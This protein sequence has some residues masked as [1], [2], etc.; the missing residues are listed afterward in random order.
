MYDLITPQVRGTLEIL[1]QMSTFA[2]V[3]TMRN[4]KLSYDIDT[5]FSP[6]SP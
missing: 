5:V 2:T 1:S 3:F 6:Y 4:L